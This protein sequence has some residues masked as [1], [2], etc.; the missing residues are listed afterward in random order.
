MRSRDKS[1][2]ARFE[3]QTA[4]LFDIPR[5]HPSIGD[6][7]RCFKPSP[8]GVNII[9]TTDS[10]C[11]RFTNYFLFGDPL[12]Q[13][14]ARRAN[15][16]NSSDYEPKHPPHQPADAVSSPRCPI[17]MWNLVREIPLIVIPTI[18]RSLIVGEQIRSHRHSLRHQS[19]IA[20]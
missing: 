1:I 18:S 10:K 19:R 20:T 17:N 3:L 6:D 8:D 5:E 12:H 2:Q 15:C 14:P 13:P 4:F 16:E 11:H 9:F 7:A